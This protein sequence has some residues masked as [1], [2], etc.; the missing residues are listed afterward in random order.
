MSDRGLAKIP[1]LP[2]RIC[3]EVKKKIFIKEFKY[4][5]TK[6]LEKSFISMLLSFLSLIN[7]RNGDW[8]IR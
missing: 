2:Q 7:Q 5:S 4:L 1:I 6:F 8:R 3:P